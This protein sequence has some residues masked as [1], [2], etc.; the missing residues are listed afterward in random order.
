VACAVLAFRV[1]ALHLGDPWD[2]QSRVVVAVVVWLGSGVFLHEIARY[3]R[4][5]SR[6]LAEFSFV[7]LVSVLFAWLSELASGSL[8]DRLGAVGF[9]AWHGLALVL[10]SRFLVAVTRIDPR[11]SCRPVRVPTRAAGEWNVTEEAGD[12]TLSAGC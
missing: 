6:C 7:G 5:I 12:E 2:D 11:P 4:G 10:L 3:T 1:D 9:F 8:W